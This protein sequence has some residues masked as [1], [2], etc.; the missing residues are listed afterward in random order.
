MGT[1]LAILGDFLMYKIP[2]YEPSII[3]VI[4][5]VVIWLWPD[6]VEEELDEVSEAIQ[7]ILY[8]ASK[9]KPRKIKRWFWES[10]FW[11]RD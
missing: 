5:L 8:P 6:E 11:G 4:A 10:E 9:P 1:G 7:R 3:A 2:R